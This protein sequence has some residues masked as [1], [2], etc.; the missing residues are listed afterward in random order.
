[1]QACHEAGNVMGLGLESS[2][3]CDVGSGR[4]RVLYRLVTRGL[5]PGT[6]RTARYNPRAWSDSRPQGAIICQSAVQHPSR[7]PP[8][9][10]CVTPYGL[11]SK[12]C[13]DANFS[14]QTALHLCHK[15]NLPTH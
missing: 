3:G 12:G 14:L 7:I 4:T 13:Q 5:P 2:L 9:T 10:F 6:T 1:M 8:R 15:H 11:N